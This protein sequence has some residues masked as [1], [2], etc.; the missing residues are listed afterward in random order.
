MPKICKSRKL[1]CKKKL[2]IPGGGGSTK[3]PLEGGGV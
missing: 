3:D 1:R 2:D